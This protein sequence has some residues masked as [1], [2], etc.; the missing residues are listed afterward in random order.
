MFVW[1]CSGYFRGQYSHL[2]G[3]WAPMR[4]SLSFLTNVLISFCLPT[5]RPLEPGTSGAASEPGAGT[6]L[7]PPISKPSG[8]LKVI[9]HRSMRI[10]ICKSSNLF[11]L[12]VVS[13]LV[14]NRRPWSWWRKQL[15]ASWLRKHYYGCTCPFVSMAVYVTRKL[16]WANLG[17]L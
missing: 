12:E 8:Y 4:S 1:E 16:M 3:E 9:F 6:N 11:R 14:E 2:A 5:Y 17:V 10:S 13:S 7:A 15:W